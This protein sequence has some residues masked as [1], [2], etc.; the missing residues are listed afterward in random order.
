MTKRRRGRPARG[1][2]RGAARSGDAGAAARSRPDVDAASNTASLGGGFIPSAA[3][4]MRS[5]RP[6]LTQQGRWMAAVL[7]C[8]GEDVAAIEPLQRG[9]ALLGEK[10]GSRRADGGSRSRRVLAGRIR[11]PGIKVHRRTTLRDGWYGHYEGIPVTSPVQTLIDLA[12]RYEGRKVERMVNEADRLGFVRTDDLRAALDDHAG[13]EGVARLRE[14]LDRRTFRYT[15]SELERAFM[16]L[17]RR[18]GL[19]PPRPRSSSTATKSTSGSR[20]SGW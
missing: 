7:A 12:P 1:R 10:C 3:A 15:R 18:A 14:I 4:S 9:A 16:P 17:V 19:R 6:A 5:G 2:S 20:T 13:E 8:G 11:V